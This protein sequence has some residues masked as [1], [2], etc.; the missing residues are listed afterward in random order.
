M[1]ETG[2]DDTVDFE[3]Q[4]N[5]RRDA[6]IAR[7]RAENDSTVARITALDTGW[8]DVN[9]GIDSDLKG[10]LE[11]VGVESQA[12]QD[13]R[14]RLTRNVCEG[15]D[16]NAFAIAGKLVDIKTKVGLPGLTVEIGF[17]SQ[18]TTATTGTQPTLVLLR[19]DASTTRGTGGTFSSGLRINT[20]FQLLEGGGQSISTETDNFGD[21]LFSIPLGSALTNA[22]G[23]APTVSALILVRFG[24]T[25]VL[26]QPR[27]FTPMP[28]ATEHLTLEIDCSGKLKDVLE[29]G[30]QVAASVAND[31]QLVEARSANFETAYTTF[32][33]MSDA[34]LSQLRALKTDLAGAAPP[35]TPAAFATMARA[36][37]AQTRF[38]GNSHDREVH[39]LQNRK[40]QCHIDEIKPDHRVFF[41]TEQDAVAAGYDFCRY[42]FGKQKSKR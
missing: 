30:K 6:V 22:A 23:A 13:A 38:L 9:G 2:N 41:A 16:K 19:D 27:T 17:A 11:T 15:A 1:D 12:I 4:I 40:K 25:V 24:D 8:E 35:P 37:A 14:D 26:R 28:G 42:C 20:N 31:A 7:K 39:D 21:F 33:Q 5:K 29:H 18:A 34:T 32:K 3:G 36:E 10:G